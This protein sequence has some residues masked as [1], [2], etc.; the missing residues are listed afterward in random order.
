MIRWAFGLLFLVL[1]AGCQVGTPK[2]YFEDLPLAYRSGFD[3]G[4]LSAWEPTDAAAWQIVGEEG[5]F[6]YDLFQL[7]A[8]KPP[9][10]SPYNI[11]ILKDIEPGDFIL[12]V[13]AKTTAPISGHRNLCVFFGYQ[14]P[15]HYYYAHFG[16]EADDQSNSIFLVNGKDR[17]SIATA[18]APGTPWDDDWHHLRI[19]RKISGLIEVFF[20]DM[21]APVMQAD[22][23]TFR[24]G[25]V[26]LGSFE[27]LGRFDDFELWGKQLKN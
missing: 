14:D 15:T 6:T 11:S 4:D 19:V 13:R 23:Q 27:D 16:Q 8:Y 18:R 7:S 3:S 20:D 21:T 1:L 24:E 25:R 10:R 9:F 2:E 5:N 12:N 17:I 22:D 26:G